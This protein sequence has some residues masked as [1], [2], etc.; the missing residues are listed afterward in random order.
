MAILRLP[1]TLLLFLLIVHQFSSSLA[2]PA[3][4]AIAELEAIRSKSPS[5]VIHLDDRSV[6]RFLTSVK[7]PRPYTLVVFFDAAH[8]RGKSDLQLPKLRS[9]FDLLSKAFSARFEADPAVYSRLFFCDIEFGQ[10]QSSFALFGVSS[11]P[12]VRVVGPK[13]T[14]LKD[15]D[16]MDQADFTRGAESM[17]DF[18]ESKTGIDLGPI[19][20]P[21]FI[22]GRQ[23]AFLGFLGIVSAPFLV[24]RIVSGD[25]MLHDPRI[26]MVGAVFIYFFSVSGAMFNVIRG[27]PMFM[28]DRNDPNKFVFFFQGSGMQLGAEGFTIGFLYTIVGLMMA[29]VTHGLVKLRSATAQRVLMG[30]IMIVS[31]W[32][33]RKVI[34][35]DNWKTGYGVHGYWPTSWS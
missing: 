23:M 6:G 35:L 7:S 8:L 16:S 34:Y 17:A 19:Q 32:A 24:R 29:L 27:M 3:A 2:D 20:R 5:G 15:S 12:H 9:E 14:N 11:L 21:P 28:M 22:S 31:L 30:L 18:L 33:V 1:S 13:I 25:T 4:D 10:S 26:W